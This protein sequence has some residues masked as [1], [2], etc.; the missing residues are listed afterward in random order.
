VVQLHAPTTLLPGR[1]PT[2]PGYEAGLAPESIWT[3]WRREQYFALAGNRTTIR[4][5]RVGVTF[6]LHLQ[7]R[8]RNDGTPTI[9]MGIS[10]AAFDT[11]S[12]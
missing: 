3:L 6:C 12:G 4:Y 7:G 1:D 10:G 11:V 8:E 9:N 2:V 5:H